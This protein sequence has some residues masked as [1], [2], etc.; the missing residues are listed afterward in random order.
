MKTALICLSLAAILFSTLVFG[1][2]TTFTYPLDKKTEERPLIWGYSYNG[3]SGDVKIKIEHQVTFDKKTQLYTYEYTITNEGTD[4]CLFRWPI[5]G[6]VLATKNNYGFGH[7]MMLTVKPKESLNVTLKS[8]DEP[9]L[10]EADAQI[11]AKI[12]DT[13]NEEELLIKGG[14]SAPPLKNNWFSLM[15]GARKGPLPKTWTDNK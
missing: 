11:W 6:R 5:L 15:S 9:V 12:P 3:F 13:L 1:Q 2:I 4:E 8:G 7:G 10:A 14:V